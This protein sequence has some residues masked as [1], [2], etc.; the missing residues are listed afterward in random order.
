M[1]IGLVEYEVYAFV[2]GTHPVIKALQ[3]SE[4]SQ[5]LDQAVN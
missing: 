4:I 3:C 1:R 2:T 5:Y